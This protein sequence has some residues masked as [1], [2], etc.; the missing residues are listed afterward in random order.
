MNDGRKGG[1]G[2]KAGKMMWSEKS[3]KLLTEMF[4]S[5]LKVCWETTERKGLTDS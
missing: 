1:K 2:K 5:V 3:L 4:I